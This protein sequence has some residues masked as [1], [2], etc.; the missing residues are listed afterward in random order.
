MVATPTDSL[1][2]ETPEPR[3]SECFVGQNIIAC[4]GP[5]GIVRKV[6]DY[7]PTCDRRTPMVRVYDGAWYGFH[8]YCI[9]CLDGWWSEGERME[10]PYARHWKRDRAKEIR[11]EWDA[12]LMPA[13]YKA[14][15]D[16]DWHRSGCDDEPC[17]ICARGPVV[18]GGE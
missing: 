5:R 8:D 2:P 16:F 15:V 13:E 6:V 12:A 11:A 9:A 14:W 10:R 4:R 7:C 18:G 3:L 1:H 17:E